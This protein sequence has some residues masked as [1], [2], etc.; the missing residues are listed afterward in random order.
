MTQLERQPCFIAGT[1]V[2]P[3]NEETLTILN[4][5]TNQPLTSTGV[6]L[7]TEVEQAVESARDAQKIWARMTAV[8]RGRI[9]NR[10]AGMLRERNEELAKLEVLNTG[11]PIA[12]A[13]SVDV[14]SGADALEYFAGIA[15]TNVGQH[16]PLGNNFAYTR[17]EPLGIVAG[18]GAWNYPLQIACWKA[19][20]ALAAG[21]AMIYKPSELT[22]LT[23]LKLAEVFQDAGLPDG[24]FSVL[25][26]DH[27]TGELLI[28][29]PA[30]R[31][32]SLT[33]GVDTGRRVME[34]AGAQL[35]QVTLELGGKSPVIIFDDADLDNA[36]KATLLANFY[37]Q[38]E[39][40]SNGTRVFVQRNIRDRFLSRLLEATRQL[41]I[42]DPLDK[43]TDVGSLISA[44]HCRSVLDYIQQGIDAGAELACGG[45]QVG[46][47]GNFVEPTIFTNCRDEMA[48]AREEI[49]GPVLCL[50]EFDDESE[51]IDRANDTEFG[52]AAGVFTRDL[53]RAHRVVAEL[54]A[55][56]C[57]INTYN[58][59]P[60]EVPFGGY[61]LSGIGRENSTLALD[62]YT[63]VKSV[64][65]EMGDLP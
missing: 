46:E 5:A 42:G 34:Q 65:V 56:T 57:W 47:A 58:I 43:Q 8:E 27:R 55:G 48:I 39:I 15:P 31:K 22:P 12:E 10:A 53:N 44:D 9:L 38:G 17:R 36:V 40:C 29:H 6:A 28:S 1:R 14:H 63:Q 61:K 16:I 41:K 20:P 59:T 25:T 26:G 4:P 11:K 24:L 30:I 19:A 51:A 62:H 33:G 2:E 35:K 32:I 64:Y 18:L 13:I 37:T 52:L 23:S 3:R 49:F 60:I 7:E 45:Q 54:Q 50:F 21:N